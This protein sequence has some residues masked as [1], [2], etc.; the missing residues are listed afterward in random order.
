MI[1]PAIVGC[2][3]YG[4]SLVAVLARFAIQDVS[5]SITELL[6]PPVKI[7]PD[8]WHARILR[9]VSLAQQRI[10]AALA[11]VWQDDEFVSE[12]LVLIEL[13]AKHYE[14]RYMIES[15][16]FGGLGLI[17]RAR[18]DGERRQRQ[19]KHIV[20]EFRIENKQRLARYV[21]RQLNTGK[22]DNS[23]LGRHRIS[24]FATL[25]SCRVS[26]KSGKE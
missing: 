23:F 8:A 13:I 19:G 3:K 25:V 1:R 18:H 20:R 12:I 14:S 22:N 16:R 10:L 11:D 26:H 15:L 2:L 24:V 6:N 9:S 21:Q 17:G 7:S 4:N 5:V